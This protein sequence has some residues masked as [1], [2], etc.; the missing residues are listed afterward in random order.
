MM[1]KKRKSIVLIWV[2]MIALGVYCR[3]KYKK[4][5]PIWNNVTIA[6]SSS[7][8]VG[9]KHETFKMILNDAGI[10]YGKNYI[11]CVPRINGKM[12]G[13]NIGHYTQD[14]RITSIHYDV[15]DNEAE[16]EVRL[17]GM[18]MNKDT[19]YKDIADI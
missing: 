17:A 2:I 1:R 4:N 11:N 10:S 15:S 3:N 8:R 16:C 6:Q 12:T 9:Q 5:N 7:I 13:C 18:L 19:T 14:D